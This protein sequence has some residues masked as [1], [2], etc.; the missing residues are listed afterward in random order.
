MPG[1][2][3]TA[4]G[5]D[6]QEL[7][8][9]LLKMRYTVGQF[10][11]VP[12]T[13]HGDCGIEGFSRDGTAFQ[14]YAPEEPLSVRER[15]KKQ[16]AKVAGDLRKLIQNAPTLARLLGDTVLRRWVLIVPRW[17]DKELHAYADEQARQVR[18]AQLPFISADFAASI[19]TAADFTVERQKLVTTRIPTLRIPL[20]EVRPDECDDWAQ[21][22]DELIQNLDRKSLAIC[23]SNA[24]HARKLRDEFVRQYLR[25]KN[26]LDK[27]RNEYPQVY[28]VAH[29]VKQDREAFLASESLIPDSLPPQKLRETLNRL[30]EQL[31]GGLP[32]IDQLTVDQLIHEAVADWLLR[33]PLDFPAA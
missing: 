23:H 2:N 8:V 21:A 31:R 14:C 24:V 3:W 1:E 7:I 30:E 11:E 27:L 25:G 16:K 6:W 29:T 15:T 13:V 22:N 17:E 4:S 26:A 5:D 32:G 28:E 18:A 10:V 20:E 12:D 9:R 19:A 33:C